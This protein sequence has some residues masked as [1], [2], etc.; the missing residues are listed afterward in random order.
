MPDD[1]DLERRVGAL[2]GEMREVRE[3]LAHTSADAQAARVLAG[4]ADRD[5]SEVRAELRA[6]M[7]VLQ[8]L[9]ETQLEQG[10]VLDEHSRILGEHSRILGA[11]GEVLGR[12]DRRFA[13]LQGGIDQIIEILTEDR[14]E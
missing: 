2:E 7:S 8:A 10:R 13:S 1:E 6:H 14:P 5:V 12:H 4:G 11:H 3:Q 9:R